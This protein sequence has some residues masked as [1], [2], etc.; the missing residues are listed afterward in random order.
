MSASMCCWAA[1]VSLLVGNGTLHYTSRNDY[2][3]PT[4]CDVF[5]LLPA[6]SALSCTT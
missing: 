6:A 1:Q 5:L 4:T 2:C 3:E